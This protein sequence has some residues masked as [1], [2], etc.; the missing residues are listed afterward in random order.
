[1]LPF[2]LGDRLVGRVDLKADRP[3]DTLCA[4]GC[5]AESWLAEDPRALAEA[6]EA[7]AVELR[8]LSEFLGLSNVRVSGRGELAPFTKPHL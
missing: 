5:F 1:M 2:L 3:A 4:K 6:G 7:L 8:R